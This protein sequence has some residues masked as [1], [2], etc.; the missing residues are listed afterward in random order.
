MTILNQGLLDS[1][2]SRNGLDFF[3]MRVQLKKTTVILITLLMLGACSIT[4]YSTQISELPGTRILLDSSYRCVAHELP[5]TW[6]TELTVSFEKV[7]QYEFQELR[8]EFQERDYKKTRSAGWGTMLT[9]ALIG[10]AVALGGTDEDGF[11]TEPNP[12]AGKGILIGSLV[13][14]GIL[15]IVPNSKD[16]VSSSVSRQRYEENEA[17][18]KED[19]VYTVWSN[20][21]PENEIVRTL[22]DE[23]I[24]LDVVTDL[25]LDYVENRDSIQVY[26]KSHWDENLIYTVDFQASDYL[27]R[28]L[29]AN[30]ITDSLSLYQ[31]PTIN[32]PI[33][34]YLSKGDDLVFIEEK[35]QWYKA[36]WDNRMVY[37]KTDRIGYFF[38]GE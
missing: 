11:Y 35:E 29:N 7:T 25:G 10:G 20:V 5:S 12:E 3:H 15:A 2:V 17:I 34:G 37:I 32:S 31:A 27:K 26:F 36:K 8:K 21:Y 9:G 6:H 24:E 1:E 30:A 14:G 13:V 33:I 4:H 23:E 22:V 18:D 19:S 38:A 16:E 28:Y